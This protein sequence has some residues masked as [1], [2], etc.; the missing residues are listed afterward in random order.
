MIRCMNTAQLGVVE[1]RTSETLT[2]NCPKLTIRFGLMRKHLG[3]RSQDRFPV[4]SQRQTTYPIR[5]RRKMVHKTSSK[6][7]EI[8]QLETECLN[9]QPQVADSSQPIWRDRG[10]ALGPEN[11]FFV[12]FTARQRNRKYDVLA[13]RFACTG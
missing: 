3:T 9:A 7:R 6:Q 11:L 1:R 8:M 10:T 13:A 12:S 4:H 5:R 2:I